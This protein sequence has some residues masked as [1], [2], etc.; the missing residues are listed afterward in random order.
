[1]RRTSSI[2]L[3]LSVRGRGKGEGQ[4]GFVRDRDGH[5]VLAFEL[6]VFTHLLQSFRR[7]IQERV[8]IFQYL[9]GRDVIEIDLCFLAFGQE[10]RV[11]DDFRESLSQN[12]YSIRWSRRRNCESAPYGK[13]RRL[14]AHDRLTQWAGRQLF[15]HRQIL[16]SWRCHS[17]THD[18][19]HD[20]LIHCD[21]DRSRQ[22]SPGIDLLALNS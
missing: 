3:A 10:L 8:K 5:A 13:R 9:L 16:E 20:T 21:L 7:L 1:M 18:G 6:D 11:L 17:A 19:S 2:P 4:E 15:I 22:G 12:S 14:N